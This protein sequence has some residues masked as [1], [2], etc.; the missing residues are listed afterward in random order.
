MTRTYALVTELLTNYANDPLFLFFTLDCMDDFL[1]T[2]DDL[3][4]DLPLESNSD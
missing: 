3:T 4:V 1:Q 2:L